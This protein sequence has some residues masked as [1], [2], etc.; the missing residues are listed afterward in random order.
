MGTKICN[1]TVTWLGSNPRSESC[2]I[3]TDQ[4]NEKNWVVLVRPTE[5][6]FVIDVVAI[7][8]LFQD[9]DNPR[10]IRLNTQ[11]N[12]LWVE[13]AD[14]RQAAA[15]LK[16]IKDLR[17]VNAIVKKQAIH[18][19]ALNQVATTTPSNDNMEIPY[20]LRVDVKLAIAE[21]GLL[22]TIGAFSSAA[23]VASIAGWWGYLLVQYAKYYGVAL[24]KETAK[25][26]CSTALLGMGG[27][28]L[29]CKT[30]TKLFHF[31]PGAGTLAAMGI[32][33][34]QNIIFTYRFAITLT[35]IFNKGNVDYDT[36]ADSIKYMFAGVAIGI[37]SIKDIVELYL[38]Y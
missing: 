12:R 13:F 11:N 26:I 22:G 14:S 18:V 10:R 7:R 33:S 27:Y 4:F 19:H 8:N 37:L 34:L 21:T 6:D 29:G 35:R 23:D 15:W 31:I 2:G 38:H 5:H 20:A 32:S 17:E 1:V 16:R 25:K 9:T 3:K 36:L 28:Y 24:D 30:A